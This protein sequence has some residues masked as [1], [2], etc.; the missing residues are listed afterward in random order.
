MHAVAL[1]GLTTNQRSLAD[2]LERQL[3]RSVPGFA[4]AVAEFERSVPL[5]E[6]ERL[7]FLPRKVLRPLAYLAGQPEVR[8]VLDGFDQ[9]PDVTREAVGEALAAAPG[10][11]A[12]GHRHA[13]RHARMPAGAHRSTTARPRARTSTVTW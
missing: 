4:G 9:L 10:P 5:P 12:P 1:L 7:D 8:I 2:D 6:R 13:A 3:R 11:P